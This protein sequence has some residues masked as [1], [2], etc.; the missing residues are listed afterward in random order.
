MKTILR[1][2]WGALL[3]LCVLAS[4][5]LDARVRQTFAR[6]TTTTNQTF[7]YYTADADVAHVTLTADAGTPD[8]TVTIYSR[9]TAGGSRTTLF[10]A[11]NPRS[12]TVTYAGPCQGTL[13]VVFTSM[14]TGTVGLEVMTR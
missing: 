11:G 9:Q 5:E 10:T 14:T 3:A 6:V 2:L 4:G 7:T 8:G 1:V 12:G 13:E